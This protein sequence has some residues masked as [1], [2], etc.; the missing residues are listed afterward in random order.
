ML[1]NS[2]T[3]PY[4][5]TGF[6]Q[7]KGAF[8]KIK[9]EFEDHLTAINENTNELQA[10]HEYMCEIDGKIE[11]L[12]QRLEN[13]ELF[14]Q[15]K[16][17]FKCEEKPSYKIDR[18]TKREQSVFLVLYTLEEKGPVSL[19]ELSRKTSFPDVLISSYIISMIQK[20]VPIKKKYIANKGYIYLDKRFKSIQAKENILKLDQKTLL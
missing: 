7:L 16:S 5:D 4:S 3:K 9:D 20:G 18:L 6:D 13:I 19:K 11:K 1:D 2:K 17:N 8:S 10:N 12:C 14:L 15:K